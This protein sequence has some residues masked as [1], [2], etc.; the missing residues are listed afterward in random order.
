MPA[1]P[2]NERVRRWRTGVL[3]LAVGAAAPWGLAAAGPAA[4][5]DHSPAT[6]HSPDAVRSQA[7]DHYAGS[8]I[9]AH[10]GVHGRPGTS[11]A[12]TADQTLGH[13]VSGHQGV[14][15]WPAASGQGARFT[16]VKATEGTDFV[17]PQFAGQYGGA[18]AAGI[19]RGAYH[20]ARPDVS[21]G[22]QQAEYFIANGGAW[23][24]DG[25]TLPGALDVEYNP[26]GD[27]CYGLSPAD[28][29]NWIA[30]F[31]RTYLAK[32]K[33]SALI[34]TSTKWWKLCTGNTS[35]FGDTDPLWVAHYATEVGELPAGWDK[36]SIWQ[37]SRTG[38]LPGD[39]NYYNG[40]MSRVQA[41]A[42]RA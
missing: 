30:D 20:F 32:E 13:D 39:Q 15:D 21:T 5:A 19:I 18:H 16:Y 9:E 24:S 10:E 35:R 37:F 17:N 1:L 22:A 14:I 28:M 36:Q 3:L 31:T 6:G 34:Y 12:G 7:A 11:R 40:P 4:A 26:Y 29:T 2:G 8:Q 42:G 33:R 25:T 41:L 27:A 23:R 38:S